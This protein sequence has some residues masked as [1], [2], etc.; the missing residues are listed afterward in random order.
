MS[1][2]YTH[3]DVYKRQVYLL[4]YERAELIAD[5][6]VEN[7]S[8]LLSVNKVHIDFFGACYAPVSYTPLFN[9]YVSCAVRRLVNHLADF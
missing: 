8:R 2:S 9:V 1:V 7:S 5:E 6:S 4:R 3:L